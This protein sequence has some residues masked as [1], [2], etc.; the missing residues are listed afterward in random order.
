VRSPRHSASLR[1]GSG[2][3]HARSIGKLAKECEPPTRTGLEYVK[4]LEKGR[5]P[6]HTKLAREINV[7]R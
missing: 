3:E 2:T 4:A 1:G 6:G 7:L 5:A